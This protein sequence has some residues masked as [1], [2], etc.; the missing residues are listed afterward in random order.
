MMGYLQLNH[1]L[2]SLSTLCCSVAIF[3][4]H[5]LFL[6]LGCFDLFTLVDL[7][8]F[9]LPSLHSVQMIIFVH[10]QKMEIC[11]LT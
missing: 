1:V 11:H 2:K 8:F 3:L 10:Y 7:F 5:F 6:S 9:P 4:P